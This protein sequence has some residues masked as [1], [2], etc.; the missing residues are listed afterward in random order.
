MRGLA[1]PRKRRRDVEKRAAPGEP[2]AR[3]RIAFEHHREPGAAI[4]A[5]WQLQT[6]LRGRGL[7]PFDWP[8]GRWTER[9]LPTTK[10]GPPKP[11]LAPQAYGKAPTKPRVAETTPAMTGA[12]GKQNA[13]GAPRPLPQAPLGG[14][15]RDPI[16]PIPRNATRHRVSKASNTKFLFRGRDYVAGRGG[17]GA[18]GLRR[19]DLD[20]PLKWRRSG[21]DLSRFS[22]GHV[23][24][25][26]VRAIEISSRFLGPRP[27]L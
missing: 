12:G 10:T 17:E 11:G 15:W 13:T 27:P 21:W 24:T 22:W 16:A 20:S 4:A 19:R 14:G 6:G 26:K 8:W 2:G 18:M 7:R 23:E 5:T 25:L 3:P 9:S 1:S